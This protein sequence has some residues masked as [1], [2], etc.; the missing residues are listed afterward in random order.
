MSGYHYRHFKKNIDLELQELSKNGALS[1]Y[2]FYLKKKI[3]NIFY[4]EK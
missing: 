1:K 2:L 4:A 3:I